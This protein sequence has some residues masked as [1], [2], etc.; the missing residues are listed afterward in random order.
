MKML[1]YINIFSKCKAIKFV[2]L[3]L[4]NVVGT[5]MSSGCMI[6]TTE[7]YGYDPDEVYYEQKEADYESVKKIPNSDFVKLKNINVEQFEDSIKITGEM[8]KGYKNQIIKKTWTE[9]TSFEYSFSQDLIIE[10]FYSTPYF[11]FPMSYIFLTKSDDNPK[12]SWFPLT[13]CPGIGLEGYAY[14][15]KKT[16][17]NEKKGVT[18]EEI[19]EYKDIPFNNLSIAVLDSNKNLVLTRN[20]DNKG[21][22]SLD[23]F[24]MLEHIDSETLT[25]NL[26]LGYND[27]LIKEK[28]HKKLTF[29]IADIFKRE[30]DKIHIEL[31]KSI[32]SG[33]LNG[34][35][36]ETELLLSQLNNL[37]N[38][39]I[40]KRNSKYIISNYKSLSAEIANLNN[41]AVSICLNNNKQGSRTSKS[42]SS[43]SFTIDKNISNQEPTG[44]GKL[45]A[46]CIGIDK[47]KDWNNLKCAVND[48]ENVSEILK[49]DYKFDSVKLLLNEE[50]TRKNIL[51]SLDKYYDLKANDSLIIY[52]SGH[53]WQ[54]ENSRSGYWVPTEAQT[55]DKF[56]YIANSQMA[57]DFFKKY[58]MKHLLVISDSCFSGTLLRGLAVR[59]KT[60][61]S[62]KSAFKKPS[63]LILTSGD[64][65]PVPDGLGDHSPF[66]TRLIQYLKYSDKDTFG[67]LDLHKYLKENLE[68]ESLCAPIGTKHMPGGE[69]I[70]NRK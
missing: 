16:I 69:F 62:P 31:T 41:Q 42:L 23:L 68:T 25:L 39:K 28:Y 70:F 58:K 63:R 60:N 27:H 61:W 49:N 34:S 1:K 12:S 53:G 44:R 29:P 6:P 19:F 2:L 50:A 37:R 57:E 17:E 21:A 43:N 46:L 47:Y 48:V 67:V 65:Q 8:A 30:Y 64:L 5:L 56:A 18:R 3:T 20:I 51:K 7:G 38:K 52:F 24:D 9:K 55:D 15:A 32:L 45:Y 35:P 14:Q 4:V 66:A 36:Q 33:S 13:W 11:I 10:F 22:V 54:D 40:T 26:E 59:K